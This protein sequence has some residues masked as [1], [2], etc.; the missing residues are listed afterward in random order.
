MRK[1]LLKQLLLF[2]FFLKYRFLI[3][4]YNGK[5]E[6]FFVLSVLGDSKADLQARLLPRIIFSHFT[7][8]PAYNEFGYY[9]YLAITSRLKHQIALADLGCPNSF[10]FMQFSG[11]F[12]K[13]VCWRP[14][15]RGNPGS[16]TE[17][18]PPVVVELGFG[19]YSLLASYA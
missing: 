6:L 10:N 4:P 17:L 18:L 1:R 8:S 19:Y 14:P 7:P 16:A 13:I 15:P 5:T 12:G 9:E 3:S 11:N 2:Q